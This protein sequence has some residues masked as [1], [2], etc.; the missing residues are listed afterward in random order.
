MTISV[1]ELVKRWLLDPTVGQFISATVGILIV[2]VRASWRDLNCY[3]CY[4]QKPSNR[5]REKKMVNVLG[6][7]PELLIV[8]V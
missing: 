1:E 2:L 7:F 4:G 6:Y 8:P 5:Y 3:G